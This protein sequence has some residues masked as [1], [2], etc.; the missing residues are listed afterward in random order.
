[1]NIF[2]AIKKWIDVSD[3]RSWVAH[4]L[5]GALVAWVSHAIG[6][7][8]GATVWSVFILFFVREAEQ[9][10]LAFAAGERPHYFDALMDFVTP[11]IAALVVS[12][13]A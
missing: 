1:M 11:S 5:V 4:S 8:V 6:L 7:N 3:P 12:L 2:A 9:A 10:A 13:V